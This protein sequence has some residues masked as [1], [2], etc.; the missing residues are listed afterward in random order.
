MKP[1]PP[2]LALV[3]F[4]VVALGVP[5]GLYALLTRERRR[6]MR[7]I[8]D[9][10]EGHGWDY[11][12]QRW[13]GSPTAFQVEGWSQC[14]KWIVKSSAGRGANR[15]W[16][17]SLGMRVPK[18]AGQVD[19]LIH[20][21]ATDRPGVDQITARISPDLQSRVA[22]LSTTLGSAVDF[23]KEATEMPCGN[24][25]FDAKYHVQV[26]SERF[27]ESPVDAALAERWLH[28]PADAIAPHS[29]LAWRDPFGVHLHARLRKTPNWATVTYFIS[30][31]DDFCARLP[32]PIP[33]P[34][35]H[36]FLDNLVGRFLEP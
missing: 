11:H 17:V 25:E 32:N 24:S 5:L 23:A 33:A 18:L 30:L 35:P 1:Y 7:E 34:Q 6:T 14:G 21:R 4:A 15:G 2:L 13:Q 19:V 8:K 3:A 27:P 31:A 12:L 22:S 29:V 36:G 16:S 28:W 10:A 9:A 26:L 20:P